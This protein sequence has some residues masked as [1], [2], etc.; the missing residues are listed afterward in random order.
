M[1]LLYPIL[2]AAIFLPLAVAFLMQSGQTTAEEHSGLFERVVPVCYPPGREP[3]AYD[4]QLVDQYGRQIRLSELWS[5]PVLVTFTYTYCPDVCPTMHFV[6]NKTLPLVKGV[7]SH[8]LDVSLDPQRDSVDRLRAYALGNRY[9]WT[10]LTGDEK[11]L[12]A[13]WR[14]YGVYRAVETR[15]GQ[16]YIVHDVVWVVVKDGKILGVVRGLTAPDTLADYVKKFV[17]RQC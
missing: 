15:N 8:V 17:A 12:E 2:F 14:A 7:V 5:S 10:F 3:A 4:F 13:V 11:T 9:N 16:P 1:R 6:L